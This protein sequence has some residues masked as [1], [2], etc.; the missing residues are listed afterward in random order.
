MTESMRASGRSTGIATGKMRLRANALRGFTIF[1]LLV[2]IGVIAVLVALV[3]LGARA[4]QRAAGSVVDQSGLNQVYDGIKKFREDMG[5]LPPMVKEYGPDV[6]FASVGIESSLITL[7][8]AVPK[9][10]DLPWAMVVAVSAD[11]SLAPRNQ[12]EVYKRGDDA[13]FL[14]AQ[15]PDWKGPDPTNILRDN[16]YS[17]LTLGYFVAGQ[18]EAP[19]TAALPDVPMDGVAGPGMYK[20][21]RAGLFEV[22]AVAIDPAPASRRRAGREYGPFIEVGA[23]GVRTVI[24]VDT[25]PTASD[26]G[27]DVTIRDRNNV[28]MRYYRWL[29]QEPPPNTTVPDTD[30]L[31]V[32][33]AIIGRLGSPIESIVPN[34]RNPKSNTL[35]RQAR[36]AVAAAGPDR[37]YGDE[38][39]LYLSQVLGVPEPTDPTAINKL[40]LQAARD[41]LVRVGT[42]EN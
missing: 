14:R 15:D 37:L 3:V 5:F 10:S 30:T 39:L 8:G 9:R 23:K 24:D 18:L 13:A 19:Y 1:E 20:P 38:P 41:N 4:A 21:D 40:R 11:P 7:P 6:S 35:L 32:L 34:E 33:P 42:D 36:W 25:T 26:K 22:P 31:L 16:R 29:R 17:E 2:S 12:I 28:P 27:K